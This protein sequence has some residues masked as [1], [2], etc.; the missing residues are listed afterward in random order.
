[1]FLLTATLSAQN[2]NAKSPPNGI[3]LPEK[4]K[5]ELLVAA[6]NLQAEVEA[7]KKPGALPAA[8]AEYTPDVE[9]FA[10][11]VLWAVAGRIISMSR[12]PMPRT[13]A[14]GR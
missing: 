9:I 14:K 6:G 10:K 12:W 7:L 8:V 1:L 5:A 2:Q 4:D 13:C 3:A 11:A